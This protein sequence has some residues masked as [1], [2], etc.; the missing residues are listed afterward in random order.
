MPHVA[1]IVEGQGEVLAL[2][3][4]LQRLH[5]HLG[6]PKRL[7]VNRPFRVKAPK[8]LHDSSE[9]QRTLQFVAAKA[10]QAGGIVLVLLDSDARTDTRCPAELGPQLVAEA[11]R[12]APDIPTLVVLAEREFESWFLA[13][14]QSL[15]GMHG[16]PPNFAPTSSQLKR[17]DAKGQLNAVMRGGYDPI[18]H[19]ALL[20][21]AMDLDLAAAS[22][23]SFARMADRLNQFWRGAMSS[24]ASG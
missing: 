9:R 2:P 12:V 10:R 24:A 11:G 14:A 20:A 3:L 4:L 21:R 7:E 16:I 19:Q 23:A 15:Q 5:R 18:Q 17:R 22:N 1:P 13:A 6:A 8:F